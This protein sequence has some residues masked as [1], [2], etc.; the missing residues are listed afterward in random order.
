MNGLPKLPGLTF[1]NFQKQQH[2]VPQTLEMKQG[3]MIPKLFAASATS[4]SVG[5][6]AG[7]NDTVL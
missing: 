1:E 5:N 6:C 7:I 3:R 2:H 4:G